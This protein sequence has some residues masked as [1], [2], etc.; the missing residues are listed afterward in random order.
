MRERRA[1]CSCPKNDGPARQLKRFRK[2]A[3]AQTAEALV[4]QLFGAFVRR[5]AMTSSLTATPHV[6][7]METLSKECMKGSSS[8]AEYPLGH[9]RQQH[10]ELA[11]VFGDDA[12]YFPLPLPVPFDQE[13]RAGFHSAVVSCCTVD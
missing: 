6:R 12:Q 4:L 7:W 11:K 2:K 8:D 10:R 3:F 1:L 5:W 13:I 9:Q